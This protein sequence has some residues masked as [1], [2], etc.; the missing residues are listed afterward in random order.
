M[1]SIPFLHGR[2]LANGGTAWHWKPSPRLRAL[3]WANQALGS[4]PGKRPSA[5]IVAAALALNQRVDEALQAPAGGRA[6]PPKLWR[7]ADLVHAYRQSDAYR[8][9]IVDSTR[10][11]YDSR[12]NQLTFIAQ[13]GA[14]PIRSIDKAMVGE[15]KKALR[16]GGASPWK[17]AALLRVLRLLMR[18]ARGEG[19]IAADPTEGVKIPTPPSR[20]RKLDWRGAQAAIAAARAAGDQTAALALAIAF[21]SFQRRA[22]LLA[23]NRMAWR[24]FEAIDPRDR[25]ALASA[26]GEVRGFRLQQQKTRTWVDCPMPPALHAQIEAQFERGQ[27]LFAHPDDPARPLPEHQMHRRCRKYLDAAGFPD[28][29]LRDFRRS[30]MSWA[31]DM[32][33]MRSD[34]R[35]VSGHKAPGGD[36]ILD[37]YMPPDTRAAARAIATAVRTLAAIEAREA[38]QRDEK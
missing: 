25:A 17:I 13:D 38:E 18:W 34:I 1:A 33:A 2:R 9:E 20:T 32:G 21:W 29:Q 12:L 31:E 26:K 23:L 19:L 3:G 10:A 16:E 15:W 24:Q 4:A 36:R 35:A 14:L 28:V 22:D 30:G 27:W 37:T 7:F 11:E 6:A 5:A 8:E